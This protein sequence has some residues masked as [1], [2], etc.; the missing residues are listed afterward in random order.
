MNQQGEK[1]WFADGAAYESYVGRWSGPIADKFVDWLAQPAGLRWV[2]VGCGTGALSATVLAKAAPLRLVG[3]EPSEGFLELARASIKDP[4]AEFRQ[5]DAQSLPLA[6]HAADV[7]VSGLVLNFLPDR[8]RALGEMRRV[9][10]P[11]GMIAL[12][13]WDY[14][15]E[16]QLMRRFWDAAS[17]LFPDASEKNEARR[18]SDC[19]P[20]PLAELFRSGGLDSVDTHALNTPT[21]FADFDDYW[22]PFLKGQGPAGAYCA[23]LPE[24]DRERLRRR[25]QSTLPFAEDGRIELIARAWA[26]RGQVPA[27]SQGPS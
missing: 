4:R 11:G 26:V 21:V 25:L 15:G 6:D 12:Y 22:L 13:V 5:G 24:D 18:F 19:T 23:A 20:A 10:G 2:D 14:A 8:K 1:D 16:M 7:V 27:A 3:I 9:V 17:E